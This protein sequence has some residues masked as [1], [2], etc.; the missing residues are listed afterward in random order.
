[1]S[2]SSALDTAASEAV[3]DLAA[4]VNAVLSS[5]ELEADPQIQALRQRLKARLATARQAIGDKRQHAAR[6]AREAAT[7]VNTY[8]REEPWN[9][10]A[11]AL[12]AGLAI[13]LS[14]GLLLGRRADD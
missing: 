10:T 4:D 6:K 11:G 5:P 1:M 2:H 7:Q 12:A 9:A 3:E 8:V 14:I 13:G